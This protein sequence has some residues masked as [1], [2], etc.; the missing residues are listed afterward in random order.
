M[1]KEILYTGVGVAA[2]VKEKVE[3]ELQNLENE[4]K[5]KTDDAKGFLKSLEEKG[6]A[7]DQKIKESIKNI[8]KE[9]IDELQIA[10]KDD[11]EKLK[12]ELKNN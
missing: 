9:V 11:L 1:L 12:N 8:F 5:I 4:G 10:T 6:I 2:F 3:K 7:E